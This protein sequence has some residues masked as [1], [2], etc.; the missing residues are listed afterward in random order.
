MWVQKNDLRP[1]KLAVTA[2]MGDQGTVDVSAA[3]S[4][5]DQP[6]TINPPAATD[7]AP[8]AS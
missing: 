3:L 7:V 2:N 4:N 6:V 1:A 8:A 5:Y